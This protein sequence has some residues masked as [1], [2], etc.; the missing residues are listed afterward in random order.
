MEELIG[1]KVKVTLNSVSGFITYTGKVIRSLDQF[2]LVDTTLGP[3]YIG[4]N[5]IKTIQVIG[6]HREEK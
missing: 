4:Y 6:D 2:V 5:S 1:Q 3:L